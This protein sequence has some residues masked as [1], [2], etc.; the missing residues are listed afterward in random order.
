M[1]TLHVNLMMFFNPF[2][3]YIIRQKKLKNKL[4]PMGFLTNHI[5]THIPLRIS[6]TLL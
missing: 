3:V 4:L 6:N 1:F 5:H 2:Y